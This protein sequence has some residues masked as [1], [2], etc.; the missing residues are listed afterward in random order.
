MGL[1]VTRKNKKRRKGDFM[2]SPNYDT[3]P[4]TFYPERHLYA[5]EKGK[6]VGPLPPKESELDLPF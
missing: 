5:S 4:I 2:K 1:I 3:R 6:E